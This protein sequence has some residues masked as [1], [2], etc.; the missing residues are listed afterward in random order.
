MECLDVTAK[1]NSLYSSSDILDS[2]ALILS[3]FTTF[4]N[5]SCGSVIVNAWKICNVYNDVKQVTNL[6]IGLCSSDEGK[7][8]HHNYNQ[9]I[10]YS[11]NGRDC[12][13]QLILLYSC[14]SSCSTALRDGA[15]RY[16]CCV[17]PLISCN[18]ADDEAN[19]FFPHVVLHGQVIAQT[20]L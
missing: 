10:A 17:N 15:V 14:T 18:N 5:P 11:N 9:L 2:I 1:I 13:D 19:V 12:Y 6:L 7:I 20:V 4:C 16:G 8:C 3:S